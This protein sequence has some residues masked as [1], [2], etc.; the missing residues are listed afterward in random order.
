MKIAKIDQIRLEQA[1]DLLGLRPGSTTVDELSRGLQTYIDLI[2]EWNPVASLISR[3]ELG[4]GL[5]DHIIDSLSLVPIL[6]IL[7]A[8]EKPWLDIGSGNGFPAVPVLLLRPEFSCVLVERT[9]KKFAFLKK[10]VATLELSGARVILGSFPGDA[11]ASAP[12]I[13]TARAVERQA[14]I[15][16]SILGSL[17]DDGVFLCQSGDESSHLPE[18]F[19]G[20]AIHDLWEQAG[21]RRGKLYILGPSS[22]VTRA[23]AALPST[24]SFERL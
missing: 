2:S 11:P 13:V 9:S 18:G 14:M 1:F 12:G 15:L 4:P 6:D 7:V 20:V 23:I 19:S 22:S 10:T 24:A 8:E 3:Q 21:L 5:V 16:P 17:S